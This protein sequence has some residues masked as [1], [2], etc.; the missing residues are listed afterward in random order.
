VLADAFCNPVLPAQD[1]PRAR[2]FYRDVLGLTLL[3]GP[4][5]DPMFF[6]A[7]SG[8]ALVVTE[9]PGR[10]P[11]PYQMVSFMVEGIDRIVAELERRG[12]EFQKPEAS[13]FAGVEGVVRGPVIDYGPVK[14]AV[15]LDTEGNLLA[16]NE[17]VDAG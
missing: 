15:F 10:T 6:Q 1:G 3:S 13:S 11:P 16:L 8:T 9:I 14:S 4:S 5:D 2:A 12:V 17:M 7:G